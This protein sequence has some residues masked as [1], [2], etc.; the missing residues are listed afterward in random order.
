M[1]H[2]TPSYAHK[3]Q[4]A[5]AV[6]ESQR[7]K[8]RRRKDIAREAIRL[9]ALALIQANRK[10]GFSYTRSQTDALKGSS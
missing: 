8:H 10:N 3:A 6:V 5:L 9:T 7:A 1:N 2:I 4:R